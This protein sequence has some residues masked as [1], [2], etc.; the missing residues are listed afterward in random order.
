ML[1]YSQKNG[2]DINMTYLF[3]DYVA[4]TN[5]IQPGLEEWVFSSFRNGGYITPNGSILNVNKKALIS[6]GGGLILPF[7]LYYANPS[8]ETIELYT[9]DD[10]LADLLEWE[11][12]LTNK[13]IPECSLKEQL[14]RLRLVRFLINV[15]KS[16]YTIFDDDKIIFDM[17]YTTGLPTDTTNSI[18]ERQRLLK[19]VLVQVCNYDAIESQL[20]R[21]ITTSKFNIYETFYDYILYDY[22]IYQIPKKIYDPKKERYIDYS[23]SKYLVTDKELRLKEEL[24]AIRKNVPLEE[25]HIYRR[26]KSRPNDFWE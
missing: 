26:C 14:M 23:Q 13:K 6:H 25:R 12:L 18:W 15:Y 5:G 17:S 7:F 10:M 9:K 21:G 16:K 19:D 22:T 8:E 3:D 11:D 24:D 1:L 2:G 20:Y 4:N